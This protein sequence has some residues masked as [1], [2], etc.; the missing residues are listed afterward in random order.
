MSFIEYFVPG[1]QF[2]DTSVGQETRNGN[3]QP[4][5]LTLAELEASAGFFVTEFLS[6]NATWVAG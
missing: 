3:L 6:F 2:K 4:A 5:Q 1:Y